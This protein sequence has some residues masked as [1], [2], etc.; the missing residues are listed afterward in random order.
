MS[1]AE[2]RENG[3]LLFNKSRASVR[4]EKRKKKIVERDGQS[5]SNT[6]SVAQKGPLKMANFIVFIHG[7]TFSVFKEYLFIT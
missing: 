5:H 4:R 2:G 3:E 6:C 1:G 7:H